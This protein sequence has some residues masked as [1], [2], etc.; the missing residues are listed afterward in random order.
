MIRR[1][2]RSTRTDTLFPY[3]TLF[4]SFSGLGGGE[5]GQFVLRRP[6][7]FPQGGPPVLPQRAAGIGIRQQSQGPRR[8]SRPP[9][10]ILHG[11]KQPFLPR[12]DQSLRPILAQTLHLPQPPA[13]RQGPPPP[14]API[15]RSSCR[16]GVCQYV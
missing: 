9:R 5:Q 1:P 11:G 4:R 8:Q 3:T 2:P 14:L 10:Q 15:G 13:Q 7:R 6:P 12:R 16:A